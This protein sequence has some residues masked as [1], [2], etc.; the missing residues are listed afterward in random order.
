MNL[1]KELEAAQTE[2]E[3][4]WV[5][6]QF[7]LD[8]LNP[9]LGKVV[10]IAAIP[11]WF[12]PEFLRALG[13]EAPEST[14]EEL[15]ELSFVEIFPGRG[16]N[17]HESSRT[18][19]LF[20]LWQDNPD[21]LRLLSK[22]A[23]DHCVRF[24]TADIAWKIEEI[25]H[26]LVAEHDKG[27]AEMHSFCRN[28][29]G[30]PNFADDRVEAMV[31]LVREHA[32]AGRLTQRAVR[33]LLLWEARLDIAYERL[34]AAEEKLL[35]IVS[36]TSG[37]PLLTAEKELTR[38]DLQRLRRDFAFGLSSYQ[39]ALPLFLSGGDPLGAAEAQIGMGQSELSIRGF[40]AAEPHFKKAFELYRSIDH[41]AGEQKCTELLQLPMP[42]LFLNNLAH[43]ER[44]ASHLA[45]R[46]RF[47]QEEAEDFLSLVKLRLVEDDYAILRKFTGR[48]SLRTYL[49]T[50][51]GNLAKDYSNHLYG[52]WR[53][54][55]E[56]LHL[57]AAA[58]F[59]ER[60]Q[61]VD[62]YSLEEACSVLRTKYPDLAQSELERMKSQLP[63]R[64]P[65]RMV[66]EESLSKLVEERPTPDQ[67]IARHEV[68][69]KL[70]AALAA[71]G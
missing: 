24:Q 43:I 66:S 61:S 26:L 62:G 68:E 64:L 59:L 52:K 12:D 50:V 51:V 14:Y 54:S 9:A 58:V 38:G 39:S 11:H 20:H 49:T 63:V 33:W 29:Y 30:L 47:G 65:R 21:R 57:G 19:L 2:E 17:I 3:R 60:L 34:D 37:D 46:L 8:G 55:T 22:Y 4:A 16:Y 23:A 18:L 25:Y 56:A 42:K 41:V 28:W 36:D 27:L 71:C 32:K 6:L 13:A 45:R 7:S 15:A 67:T 40:T 44:V 69:G 70:Q 10:W 48:S 31:R 1:L 35:E 53:P 5:V